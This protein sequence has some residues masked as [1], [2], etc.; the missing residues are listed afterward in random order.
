MQPS[1]LASPL[2]LFTFLFLFLLISF[3]IFLCFLFYFSLFSSL[4]FFLLFFFSLFPSFSTSCASL[5]LDLSR[6]F[7]FPTSRANPLLSD[8]LQRRVTG[9]ARPSSP[10]RPPP[11]ST[12][13]IYSTSCWLHARF[14]LL[15]SLNICPSA[16]SVLHSVL[17]RCPTVYARGAMLGINLTESCSCTCL[18][19][20]SYVRRVCR[21]RCDKLVVSLLDK[22]RR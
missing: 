14:Q 3:I 16:G 2:S 4:F 15:S 20:V 22:D 12:R 6:L 10:R 11:P 7:L 8:S 9:P 5:S 13:S 1:Q 19:H 21:V 18:C 17:L